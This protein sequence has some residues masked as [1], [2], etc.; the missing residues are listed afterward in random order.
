MILLKIL[1]CYTTFN[2][3][4]T[5]CIQVAPAE[6]EALLLAHPGVKDAAVMGIPDEEAGELPKAF[7]VLQPG[8]T[9]SPQD[10]MEFV[11]GV[12]A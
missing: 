7:V 3:S 5:S 12:Q 2:H 4:L 6:L 1:R 9:L 8:Q 10:I 11:K